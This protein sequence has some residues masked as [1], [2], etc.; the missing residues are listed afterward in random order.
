MKKM[1]RKMFVIAI[2][3]LIALSAGGCATGDRFIVHHGDGTVLDTKTNLMWAAKDNDSDVSWTGAKSYCDNFFA[4]GYKDWR[5]PTKDELASLY[6]AQNTR[7]APCAGNFNIHLTTDLIKITCFAVW[8]SETRD[9]DAL[10]FNFVY[11]KEF[12]YVPSHT[13][14]TRVLP[15][16]SSK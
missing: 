1:T 9:A 15:V 13:Y 6:D 8:S 11:G 14:G 12:W 3:T 16:R 5:M 4:G 10:H 2:M 7:P